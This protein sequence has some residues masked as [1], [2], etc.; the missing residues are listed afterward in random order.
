MSMLVERT[1][2]LG[3]GVSTAVGLAGLCGKDIC[4]VGGIKGSSSLSSSVKGMYLPVN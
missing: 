2:G 3:G 4:V 1:S